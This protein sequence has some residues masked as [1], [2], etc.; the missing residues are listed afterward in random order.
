[1]SHFICIIC[2]MGEQPL[3]GLL[4]LLRRRH[5]ESLCI[6][7]GGRYAGNHYCHRGVEVSVLAKDGHPAAL[8]RL[9]LPHLA[10]TGVVTCEYLRPI[11]LKT[12]NTT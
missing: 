2:Q 9:R 11:Y 3:D 12:S 8:Q 10:G 7:C 6:V 5:S 1:M 4:H